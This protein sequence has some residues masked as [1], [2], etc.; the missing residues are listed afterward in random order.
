MR[1]FAR[2]Y[3]VKKAHLL[4]LSVSN[5][6]SVIFYSKKSKISY[7]G[8]LIVYKDMKKGYLLDSGH[9]WLTYNKDN[10]TLFMFN[11]KSS[12]TTPFDTITHLLVYL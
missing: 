4:P 11:P 12:T 7:K 3:S 10:E 8:R 1:K 6:T 5:P 2:F 9:G